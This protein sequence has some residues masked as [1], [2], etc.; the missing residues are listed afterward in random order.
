MHSSTGPRQPTDPAKAGSGRSPRA[1]RG[2]RLSRNGL[3]LLALAALV[4][5]IWFAAD[6]VLPSRRDEGLVLWT[7]K[8]G[9]LPIVVT[10]RGQLES[11]DDVTIACEVEDIDGDGIR[12][13]PLLWVV[14]NGS[15]VK[16][17]DLL[18]E[19]DFSSHTERL[20]RQILATQSARNEAIQETVSFENQ[21]TQNE[22]NLAEAQL[23][24]DLAQLA[25]EQFEDED[26]GTF[27]INLQDIE[28]QIQEARASKL[29]EETNLAGVQELYDLGYRSSGELSQARLSAL[30]AERQLAT[31]LSKKKELVAYQYLKTKLELQGAL[32]SA[33]RGMKQVGRDNEAL[34]KQAE[35][36]KK[37]ADEGLLK[38][39]ERLARYRDQ[40]AKCKIFAPQDGMVAY[41]N[42]GDHWYHEEIRQG[43]TIRQRQAILTLPN[44]RRMQVTTSVH[45]S[46]RE[47]IRPGL[48]AVV[49]IDTGAERVY[50]ASVFSVAVLPD[51]DR[52]SSSGTKVYSTVVTIDEDV[53]QL[54]PGM[55]AVV[56]I[57]VDQLEN[58]LTVPV[59]AVVQRG[60]KT[61]C[62]VATR[63]G[64]ERRDVV[65]GR[66]NEKLVEILSG[67]EEGDRVVLNPERLLDEPDTNEG[68]EEIV[69][70]A[71]GRAEEPAVAL[72]K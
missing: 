17:G 9:N 64:V 65:L 39:E 32:A 23:K 40:I 8:R 35:A 19:L 60:K 7:L 16:A 63:D 61:W 67:L 31:A 46:V 20:D 10:E 22:T 42:H 66:T 56:D 72:R 47:M 3:V 59:Q 49:R 15:S 71:P 57:R 50:Q 69:P 70:K 21:V 43:A 12:G 38:E 48:P 45:E 44:L 52:R 2:A 29:I 53:E 51:E 13:T 18:V 6:R 27:Q 14:P 33:K 58:A 37:T 41:A 54:K 5:G 68:A 1:S 11:Q 55:T 25:L 36:A 62:S 4:G 26:G 34:L 30:K 24:V 28:L